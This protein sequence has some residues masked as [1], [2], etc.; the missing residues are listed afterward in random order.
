MHKIITYGSL[1][2]G[3]YNFDRFPSAKHIKT[4][5]IQGWDLFSLHSG[6]YPGVKESKN[7]NLTVDII[8]V[9]AKDYNNIRAMELGAGYSEIELEVENVKGKFYP[10]LG[11]VQNTN[12]IK[13]GDWL[14]RNNK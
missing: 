4:T 5:T 14:K 8:E 1:R 13:S 12:I 7:S 3:E 10:Y 11:V 2:K 9:D 6:M